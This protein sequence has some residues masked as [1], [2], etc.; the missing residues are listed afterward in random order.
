MKSAILPLVTRLDGVSVGSLE[1]SPAWSLE[2]LSDG[3]NSLELILPESV[4]IVDVVSVFVDVSLNVKSGVGVLSS[5][6]LD[7]PVSD[8]SLPGV[9]GVGHPLVSI[10]DGVVVSSSE[11]TPVWSSEVRSELSNSV[12]LPFPDSVQVSDLVSVVVNVSVVSGL[13]SVVGSLVDGLSPSSDLVSPSLDGLSD[14]SMSSR[15]V[16]SVV[17]E[18]NSVVGN[19]KVLSG[20]VNSRNLIFP[21]SSHVSDL[22]G[23]RVDVSVESSSS[24]GILGS[25]DLLSPSM[26]RSS[27]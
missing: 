10:S 3:S 11:L 20:S 22:I 4:H 9:D 21:K 27:Q 17:S 26:D 23:I 7:S 5:S 24:V 25:S 2:A 8:G 19:L 12:L 13:G 6:D 18:E 16:S 14:P 15:D 1:P